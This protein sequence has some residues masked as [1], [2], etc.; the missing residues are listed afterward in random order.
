MVLDVGDIVMRGM[1]W[2]SVDL[3][4]S[5]TEKTDHSF[6]IKSRIPSGGIPSG[7]K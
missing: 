5:L 1:D 6:K 4:V 3:V 2:G 7:I